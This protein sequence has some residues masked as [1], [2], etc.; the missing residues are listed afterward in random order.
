[1]TS[2]FAALITLTRLAERKTL[3]DLTLHLWLKNTAG[4]DAL[5]ADL[6]DFRSPDVFNQGT[7]HYGR[8]DQLAYGTQLEIRIGGLTSTTSVFTE[9]LS[10]LLTL[11]NSLFA[12]RLPS[13][14]YLLAE[15]YS[16]T[17]NAKPDSNIER[18]QQM[19][20]LLSFL[21][22]VADVSI[23]EDRSLVFLSGTRLD[24]DIRYSSADLTHL[25][26]PTIIEKFELEVFSAPFES[27]KRSMLKSVLARFL[28]AVPVEQRLGQLI[29]IWT[30]V[31]D[32]YKADFEL[33]ETEFNFEK[34]RE[35]FEQKKLDYLLK[36]NSATAD[37]LTKLLAIPVAQGLLVSQLK[38]DEAA[39]LANWSLVVAAII[40]AVIALLILITHRQSILQIDQELRLDRTLMSER[41]PL[42]YQRVKATYEAVQ[43]RARVASLYPW[44]LGFVLLLATLFTLYAFIQ[45]PPFG[46]ATLVQAHPS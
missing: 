41:F 46:P 13:E 27:T 22:K 26:S 34:I 42:Q 28:R 14:Y 20:R 40:F 29:R 25:P 8:V 12:R 3:D 21:K 37:S 11:Q 36:L 1:M 35:S 24:I 16:S 19:P 7:Q 32:A 30:A 6:N 38:G 5:L 43:S 2:A 4:I 33:Y 9:N 31:A 18:Y 23:D 45:V 15:N 39:V 10:S 17:E 44:L